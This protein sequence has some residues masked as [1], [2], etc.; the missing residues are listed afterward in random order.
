V[1]SAAFFEQVESGE[2]SWIS[3]D[4]Q[5]EEQLTEGLLEQL[6]KGPLQNIS[7]V[8]AAIGFLDLVED[9]PIRYGTSKNNRLSNDQICL[10]I[11]PWRLSRREWARSYVCHFRTSTAS[12]A[13]G[14]ARRVRQ[15]AIMPDV[16][17][18]LLSEPRRRLVEI[19]N[20]CRAP[21]L[22]DAARGTCLEPAPLYPTGSA[23]WQAAV[24]DH[25]ARLSTRR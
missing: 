10:A 25:H 20:G 6:R 1:R 5:F 16:V 22:R 8:S 13:I 3:D 19:D 2:S 9:E 21:D 15:L 24:S 17:D 23:W 14:C 18:Q 4:P 12:T 7:D 11:K